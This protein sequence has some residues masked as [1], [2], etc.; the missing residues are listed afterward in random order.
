[1]RTATI[2]RRQGRYF[3]HA[4]SQTSDGLLLLCEPV[5]AVSEHEEESRF[6]RL[7]LAALDG[8]RVDVPSPRSAKELV[9]PLLAISGTRSW[10]AFAR[11]AECVEISEE[12]GVLTLIPTRN[13]GSR[14]GFK[15]LAEVVHTMPDDPAQ[16]GALVVGVLRSAKVGS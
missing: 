14:G 15:H 4:L 6:G 13:L 8:F 12:G 16:L 5:F 2:Y 9:T 1:V 3:V 11:N 7:I 10:A